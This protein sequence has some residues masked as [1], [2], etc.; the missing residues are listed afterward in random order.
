MNTQKSSNRNGAVFRT[1]SN[2]HDGGFV[3]KKKTA[4]RT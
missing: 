2:D 4:R 3:E 1:L